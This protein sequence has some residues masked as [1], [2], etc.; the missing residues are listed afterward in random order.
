MRFAL[1]ARYLYAIRI[2]TNRGP[3]MCQRSAKRTYEY[4]FRMLLDAGVPYTEADK[5][6]REFAR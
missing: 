3:A 6:A 4:L 1:T 5:V 2:D